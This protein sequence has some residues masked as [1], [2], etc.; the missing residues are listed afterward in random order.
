MYIYGSNN[1]T[2]WK[3]ICA[4]QR[5]D[6]DISQITTDRAA[7]AYK[8]FIIMIGGIVPQSTELSNIILAIEDVADKKLR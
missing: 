8:H 6:C 3:C 1:L 4:A 5:K 7:K 2:K